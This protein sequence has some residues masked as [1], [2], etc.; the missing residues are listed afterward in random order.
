[1][2]GEHD[3]IQTEL[4]IEKALEFAGDNST[5]QKRRLLILSFI[6]LS[7]AILTA[8][9]PLQ[10]T[11]LTM[12]FLVASGAGQIVCPIYMSLRT[13]TLGL[14]GFAFFGAAFYPVNSLLKDFAYLGL[15]F[16]GRG[17][18]VSSLIYLNEIG[19]DRFRAWSLL[20][21]FGI[22]GIS[23]LF[24]SLERTMKLPA[25]IFNYFFIFL[26]IIVD[27]Y[28]ILQLWKPSPFRLFTK[29]ILTFT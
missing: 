25:W 2:R 28:F 8:K 14:A 13:C 12:L 26:P 17:F 11:A 22:W 27:S 5:Y 6:I 7:L 4:S 9:I 23:S 18:Y 21:V 3:V 1:M 20:V 10:G 19:G 24:S 16:F 29:R 15:G